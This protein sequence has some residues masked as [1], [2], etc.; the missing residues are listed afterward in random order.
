MLGQPVVIDNRPPA[1]TSAPGPSRTS[2]ADG[3]AAVHDPGPRWSRRRCSPLQLGY[4][5]AGPG[6][7]DC[8]SRP[9]PTC[10]GRSGPRRADARDFVRRQGAAG[11]V[12]LRQRRQWQR[13]AP[14]RW[15]C[16]CAAPAFR[17][18]TCRT[19][20]FPQI[21]NARCSP[22]RCG[23][24][25]WCRASRWA[26]CGRAS[27][28]RSASRRSA[29]RRSRDT[30]AGRAGATASFEAIVASRARAGEDAAGDRRPAVD[31]ADPRHQG[32]D[33]VHAHAGASTSAQRARRRSA[34]RLMKAKAR[35]VGTRSSRRPG[36][37]PVA[38]AHQAAPSLLP[39]PPSFEHRYGGDGVAQVRAALPQRI[40]RRPAP[41]RRTTRARRPG[42]PFHYRRQSQSPGC[43]SAL[44]RRCAL[45]VNE[46]APAAA[47][48]QT[49]VRPGRMALHGQFRDNR[50]RRGLGDRSPIE[51]ERL[52]QVQRTPAGVGS[53]PD[54]VAGV[55]RDL[56]WTGRC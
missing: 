35:R 36:C 32:S 55:G 3:C 52:D 25:S 50:A 13:V 9:R 43:Q 5:P 11:P 8:W 56:G 33:E 7:I 17:S 27:S 26:R 38:F 14:W 31:R 6:A 44:N 20:S 46:S 30:D 53:E 40:G 42:Q 48:P 28:T 1:P 39:A 21:V 12:Q 4:D 16:S 19:G 24:R 45:V 18:S 37:K 47:A 10:C 41:L 22:G 34:R 23:R 29:S 54:H 2:R 49:E 51:T 15:N